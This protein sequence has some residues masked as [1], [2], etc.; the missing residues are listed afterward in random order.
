MENKNAMQQ[1]LSTNPSGI[2][3]A[4]YRFSIN[5]KIMPNIAGIVRFLSTYVLSRNFYLTSTLYLQNLHID[6][7][8]LPLLV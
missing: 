8:W 2:A 7:L 4:A 5:D 1:Q 3:A 6:L